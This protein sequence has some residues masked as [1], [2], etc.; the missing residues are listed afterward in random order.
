MPWVET[1]ACVQWV[2]VGPAPELVYLALGQGRVRR[3]NPIVASHASH[4]RRPRRAVCFGV[5]RDQNQFDDVVLV[6][7]TGQ[8]FGAKIN[9]SVGD[10]EQPGVQVEVA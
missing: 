2:G 1:S 9:S 3:A 4:E 6:P 5:I 10:V 7:M 8:L